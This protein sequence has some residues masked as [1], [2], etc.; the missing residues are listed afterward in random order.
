MRAVMVFLSSSLVT[1]V[2][3]AN[4]VPPMQTV[5]AAQA[6]QHAVPKLDYPSARRADTVDDYHG[7]K[8]PAPYEWMEDINSPEVA[9]WVEQENQ[10]TFSY[11]D[12]IPER[13]WMQQRLKQLW[14]YEKVGT[15]YR[16][17]GKLFFTRNTGLQN[18]AEVYVQGPKDAA[19]ALV[20][21][22]NSLS[23]D[24]SVALLS[25]VPST[26]ARYFTYGLSQGGSDWEEL[27]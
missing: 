18:Q 2:A 10:L 1:V 17:G 24:G 14:N 12:K 3:M 22:P 21:D 20:M 4:A 8:V 25:W 13:S 23:P 26:T 11:L 27:H 7:V 5:G 15:P 16:I 19:P 6:A 9:K